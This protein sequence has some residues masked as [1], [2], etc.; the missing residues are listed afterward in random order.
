MEEI[1]SYVDTL[2][3]SAAYEWQGRPPHE[4]LPGHLARLDSLCVV[5]FPCLALSC[6]IFVIIVLK[7]TSILRLTSP[8]FGGLSVR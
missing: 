6:M 1:Q 8:L 7:S 5:L 3:E 4:R 2:G